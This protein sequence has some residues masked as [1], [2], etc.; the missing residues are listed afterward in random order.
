MPEPISVLGSDS[1][2]GRFRTRYRNFRGKR[3]HFL[4]IG[5]GTNTTFM[6]NFAGFREEW[7]SSVH[8]LSQTV[9]EK[10][11]DLLRGVGVEPVSHLIRRH[12]P[13]LRR[14][15]QVELVEAAVSD[16]EAEV[17][18]LYMLS[19]ETEQQL[20]LQVDEK[21][22]EELIYHLEF[23]K[24]MSSGGHPHPQTAGLIASVE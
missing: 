5:L 9:S 2:W 17:M 18:E 4:Q 20:L 10:R 23:I 15:P 7:S 14:L 1:E 22:K 11:K 16:V 3:L 24:N 12:R 8:W 6:Q 13:L 19:E 21:R